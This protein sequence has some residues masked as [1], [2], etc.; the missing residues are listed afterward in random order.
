MH[1]KHGKS[2]WPL[3][4]HWILSL[5]L[6]WYNVSQMGQHFSS[7]QSV[8]THSDRPVFA[9]K[10]RV[11]FFNLT[12]FTFCG[13]PWAWGILGDVLCLHKETGWNEMTEEQSLAWSYQWTYGRHR[14][15]GIFTLHRFTT[16]SKTFISGITEGDQHVCR[17]L[18]GQN[19]I[20]DIISLKYN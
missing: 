17:L 16:F 6:L 13:H 10:Q 9:H 7:E 18:I 11:R 4:F 5:M 12:F 8:L 14:T 3:R 19:C 20:H 1:Y 15:L 2:A